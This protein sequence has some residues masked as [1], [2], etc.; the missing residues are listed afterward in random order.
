MI[1]IILMSAAYGWYHKDEYFKPAPPE[2]IIQTVQEECVPVVHYVKEKAIKADIV[3]EYVKTDSSKEVVAVATVPEHKGDTTIV[4]VI[5]KDSG[6]TTLNTKKE[7]PS[8]FEIEGI[9]SLGLRCNVTTACDE[10]TLYGSYE[11]LRVGALHMEAYGQINSESQA[12][13]GL[14]LEYRF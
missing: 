4:A 13:V 5:D 9:K 2:L 3:P 6:I 8:L 7:R 12:Y 14:G 1:V 11:F 10:V